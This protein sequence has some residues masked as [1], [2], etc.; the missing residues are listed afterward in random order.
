[1]TPQ[2]YFP[3]LVFLLGWFT[4]SAQINHVEVI[5]HQQGGFNIPLANDAHFG[6]AIANIGDLDNDGIPDLGIGALYQDSITPTQY[7]RLGT[8][9]INLMKAD[10][11]VKRTLNLTDTLFKYVFQGPEDLGTTGRHGYSLEG[12]GDIN[13]DGVPD[14]A[15]GFP[16]YETNLQYKDAG[17][18][19]IL[20]MAA[21][22]AIKGHN[23]LD[24]TD[25]P[26]LQRD[27]RFGHAITALGDINQDGYQ[28]IA[29][30][31]PRHEVAE[32]YYGA[33]WNV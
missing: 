17:G 13:S 24:K 25:F 31:A 4:S 30:S 21:D 26:S 27:D 6:Q 3:F 16:D 20:L 15:L 18:V 11:T 7:E 5:G 19:L 22:G 12:I 14:L 8:F 2:N 33:V 23:W 1:M 28:E 32:Q 29:I 9:F 10:G